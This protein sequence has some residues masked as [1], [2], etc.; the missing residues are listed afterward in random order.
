MSFLN[1]NTVRNNTIGMDS[2][3]SGAQIQNVSLK[4]KSAKRIQRVPVPI[5]NSNDMPLMEVDWMR[6]SGRVTVVQ[7]NQAQMPIIWV[8]KRGNRPA[9]L[10]NQSRQE[11]RV[12]IPLRFSGSSISGRADFNNLYNTG[13]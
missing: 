6:S 2:S 13:E 9:A 8:T 12:R 1:T 11:P 10:A 7:D 4:E 3:S 5:S